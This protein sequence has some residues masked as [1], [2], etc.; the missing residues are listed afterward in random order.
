MKN[1][2]A[3]RQRQTGERDRDRDRETKRERERGTER[4]CA[5]VCLSVCLCVNASVLQMEKEK[6]G[7]Q[8]RIQQ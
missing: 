2:E 5:N 6:Y 4:I 1:T 3:K 8:A 7:T